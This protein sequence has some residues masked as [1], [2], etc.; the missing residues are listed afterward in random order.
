MSACGGIFDRLGWLLQS[1]LK[2][3]YAIKHN[4]YL[5]RLETYDLHLLVDNN[6]FTYDNFGLYKQIRGLAMGNRLRGTLAILCMD[7]FETMHIYQNLQPPLTIYVRYVDDAGTVT[8]RTEQATTTLTYLNS[9]HPTIK[10]EMELPDTDGYLQ[11]LDIKLYIIHVSFPA[12]QS[13]TKLV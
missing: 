12:H 13:W 8:P 2:P 10:F 11:I 6:I 3:L 7:C 9:K 4:L 5:H 1:I